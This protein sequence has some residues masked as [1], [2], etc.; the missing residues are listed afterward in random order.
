MDLESL[1]RFKGYTY[2]FKG[3]IDICG[4]TVKNLRGDFK[5]ETDFAKDGSKIREIINS[6]RDFLN[7]LSKDA[8]KAVIEAE[9]KEKVK[10]V[11]PVTVSFDFAEYNDEDCDLDIYFDCGKVF[12]GFTAHVRVSRDGRTIEMI[13]LS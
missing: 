8:V 12:G 2:F 5:N 9:T 1:V 13:G 11:K 4:M 3:E 7:A 10:R 6:K